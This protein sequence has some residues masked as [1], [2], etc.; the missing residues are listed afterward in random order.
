MKKILLASLISCAGAAPVLAQ[1]ENMTAH[2]AFKSDLVEFQ[3][4]F[5]RSLRVSE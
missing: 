3:D 2:I 1:D 5:Y 4:H